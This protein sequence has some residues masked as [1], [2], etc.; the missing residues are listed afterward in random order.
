MELIIDNISL[1]VFT[2]DFD[3][4]RIYNDISEPSDITTDSTTTIDVYLSEENRA[5]LSLIYRTD[6]IYSKYNFTAKL[7]YILKDENNIILTGVCRITK[8]TYK[9]ISF[10]L[11]S[12][13]Y[14]LLSSLQDKEIDYDFKARLNKE[15]VKTCWNKTNRYDNN[16]TDYIGFAPVN[17]GNYDNFESGLVYSENTADTDLKDT[18][19]PEPTEYNI[20][21]FMSYKQRPFIFMK[22]LCNIFTEEAVK[23]GYNIVYSEDFANS[24]NPYW[25]K[26]VCLLDNED[27]EP[28]IIN[29]YNRVLTGNTNSNTALTYTPLFTENTA[30]SINIKG[31]VTISVQSS[32]NNLRISANNGIII[33]LRAKKGSNIVNY[34]SI[35]LVDE[36]GQDNNPVLTNKILSQHTNVITVGKFTQS[37]LVSTATLKVGIDLTLNTEASIDSYEII[38]QPVFQNNAVFNTLTFNTWRWSLN[39]NSIENNIN[40]FFKT[41]SN[42]T[43]KSI[44]GNIKPF[45]VWLQYIKMMGLLLEFNYT[46]NTLYILT[47]KEYFKNT[48]T[49]DITD[50]VYTDVEISKNSFDYKELNFSYNKSND[51]NSEAYY[52][53]YNT[54]Y[55]SVDIITDNIYS[56]DNK[57]FIDN[58][59]HTPVVRFR[60][61]QYKQN[62]IS[63]DLVSSVNKDGKTISSSPSY[64]FW[65][66]NVS[67]TDCNLY[68]QI[69]D[70]NNYIIIADVEKYMMNNSKYY[71]TTDNIIQANYLTRLTEYITVDNKVYSS[72]YFNTAAN[73]GIYYTDTTNIFD[74]HRDYYIDRLRSVELKTSVYK[75]DNLNF[76]DFYIID[77]RLFHLENIATDLCTFISVEDINNYRYDIFE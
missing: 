1:E 3:I 54:E 39:S 58:I 64:Y 76:K 23:L 59:Y 70:N 28:N 66:G 47:K 36:L 13:L 16:F 33:T 12:S 68:Y 41:D 2:E 30:S 43:L 73:F 51:A 6:N 22:K 19:F 40:S 65:N 5:N 55:G 72:L 56:K 45:D 18:E 38:V 53:T 37:Q 48:K 46:E 21:E 27:K 42:I 26:L 57:L 11:Y 15:T 14:Y 20:G 75:A 74:I 50:R 8:A 61:K 62:Y 35:I 77:N 10:E 34:N 24:N 44:F 60:N 25:D 7:P 69:G 9:Y 17:Q 4:N 52:N 31:T 32:S 49:I 67:N 71:Y 63:I 29:S